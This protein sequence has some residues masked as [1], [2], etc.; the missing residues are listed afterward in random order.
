MLNFSM[1]NDWKNLTMMNSTNATAMTPSQLFQN[2]NPFVFLYMFII[3]IVSNVI[4]STI[5]G[6]KRSL[7]YMKINIIL[8]LNYSLVE[9]F[10]MSTLALV[11][12]RTIFTVLGV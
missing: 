4:T 6:Y 10:N 5:R 3:L 2:F 8:L 12:I 11:S 1:T 7:S 9:A